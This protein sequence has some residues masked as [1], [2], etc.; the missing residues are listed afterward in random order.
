[1]SEDFTIGN[2]KKTGLNGYVCDFPFNYDSIVVD[3]ILNI[4]EYILKKQDIGMI[5]RFVKQ[6]FIL[7]IIWIISYKMCIVV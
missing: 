7:R 3:D 2:L 5:I 1:M 6:V 4:Y